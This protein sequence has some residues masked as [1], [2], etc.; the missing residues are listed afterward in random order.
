MF[1]KK[2]D[3]KPEVEASENIQDCLDYGNRFYCD[4]NTGVFYWYK[5]E[6]DYY[7][8]YKSGKRTL[9][10]V[11]IKRCNVYG[12]WD[13]SN[14][15]YNKDVDIQIKSGM[16]RPATK[17]EAMQFK[18]LNSAELINEFDN[19]NVGDLYHADYNVHVVRIKNL[20]ILEDVQNPGCKPTLPS[21]YIVVFKYVDMLGNETDKLFTDSIDEFLKKYRKGSGI[22][23]SEIEI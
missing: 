6:K 16:L 19:M 5:Y 3:T 20:V 10:D 23:K 18:E 12:E 17:E 1:K 13:L 11:P 15:F 4:E 9:D 8:S 14:W 7:D 21:R 2:K 22:F